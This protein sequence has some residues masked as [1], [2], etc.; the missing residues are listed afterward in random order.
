MLD[1]INIMKYDRDL[2]SNDK[3]FESIKESIKTYFN[4]DSMNRNNV[5][6]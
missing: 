1:G 6:F 3:L 4:F 2:S 5:F